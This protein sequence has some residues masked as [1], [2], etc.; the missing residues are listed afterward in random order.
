MLTKSKVKLSL[1]VFLLDSFLGW[2]S[3]NHLKKI[4]LST[5]FASSEVNLPPE[6]MLKLHQTFMLTLLAIISC[7]VIA[8]MVVELCYIK[9][10]KFAQTY[11]LFYTFL[12]SLSG[13]IMIFSHFI[14]IGILSLIGFGYVFFSLKLNSKNA[15]NP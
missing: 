15:Q 9:N 1:L 3:Y 2:W 8:H 11:L 13:I 4:N 14:L 5:F 7:F 12:A 6:I 10:K